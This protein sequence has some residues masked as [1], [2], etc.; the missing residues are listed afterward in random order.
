MGLLRGADHLGIRPEEQ[1]LV[2]G[3]QRCNARVEREK[4]GTVLDQESLPFL[5]MLLSFNTCPSHPGLGLAAQWNLLREGGVT[6]LG[7]PKTP[8]PY[9]LGLERTGSQALL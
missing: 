1:R 5:E 9:T 6:A 3:P 2:V 4:K 7:E 8:P